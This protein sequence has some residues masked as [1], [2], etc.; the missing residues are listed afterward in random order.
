MQHTQPVV[1]VVEDDPVQSDL[2]CDIL[3]SDGYRVESAAD[4]DAA[5]ARMDAGDIDLILLDIGLPGV[6]GVAI[7]QD[8]R[9]PERPIRPPIIMLSALPD[10][11]LPE[12]VTAA[13][14]DEYIA[15]P[16]DI[17]ELLTVIARHCAC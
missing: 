15:K 5:L 12:T 4:G 14:A 3:E 7:C 9:T 6:D 8:I 17:D 11:T 1:L 16:F 10:G 2:L 13:G